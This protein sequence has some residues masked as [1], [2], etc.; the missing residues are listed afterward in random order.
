MAVLKD[1]SPAGVLSYFEEISK[2]PRPSGSEEKIGQYLCDLAEEKGL[3]HRMD[4][5]GNVVIIREASEGFEER[6]PLILQAHMDMVTAPD[7]PPVTLI[8]EGDTIHADGTTLGA[9]DGIGVAMI[10]ALLTEDL[11]HPR[12]EAL[13]TVSE[14]TGMEGAFGMDSS[15]FTGKQLI[16]LDSE[17]EGE[18]LV[19]CAG[20]S[21][22]GLS[23]PIEREEKTNVLAKIRLSGGLGG[24]SGIEINKE[25]ANALMLLSRFLFT[26]KETVDYDLISFSGGTRNNVIPREAEAD[27]LIPADQAGLL[28]EEAEKA[29]KVFQSEFAA[30]DPDLVLSVTRTEE[31]SSREVLTKASRDRLLTLLA[32]LPNGIQSMNPA[33]PDL[34]KT[35]LN[36]GVLAL[37]N[38]ECKADLLLRSSE[39][40]ERVWM[41][42]RLSALSKVMGAELQ[43]NSPYPAWEWRKD[44]PLRD[45]MAEVY[46]KMFHKAPRITAIHAGLE[47]GIL[48]EKLPDLD[49][50][51]LGPDILGAHTKEERV[52]VASVGRV[53]EFL[54][55]FVSA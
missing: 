42:Q 10:L 49:A 25:R 6:E 37:E 13:F 15:P 48:M 5:V 35:S 53:Y 55:T 51:S 34:V 47:C 45:R 8:L 2:I 12:L 29:G 41:E 32:L 28:S 39:T 16:N 1:L 43:I 18:F 38:K 54:R 19:S 3:W 52:S 30:S 7:D 36:I 23:L 22:A 31:Q 11:P 24:H 50:I 17:T 9:D 33:I 26:L 21:T 4:A 20:G 46:E 44:S 27:V 40:S 14:E